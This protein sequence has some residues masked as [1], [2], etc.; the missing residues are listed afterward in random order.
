MGGGA[1][2]S[3]IGLLVAAIGGAMAA[4]GAVAAEPGPLSSP[5]LTTAQL[6]GQRVVHG[7]S[8]AAPGPDL[9]AR[10]RR[11]EV[12]GVIIMGANVRSPTQLRRLTDRLQA[13]PRPA[14][15]DAPLLVMID[16]EGGAVRRIHGAPE[17]SAS[18]IGRQGPA[19]AARAGLAAGRLLAASGV[20]VNLAPVVDVG[21]PGSALG[22]VGRLFGAAPA[23]VSIH[24]LAFERG[25][26]RAGILGTAKH[27]PG[28]G[29]AAV[30]TDDAP[31]TIS[32]SRAHLRSRHMRP[33]AAM[34]AHGVPL[35]MTSSAIY[36]GLHPGTPALLSARVVRGELRNRLGFGG[37]VITDALDTPALA[38]TG[39]ADRVTSRAAAA[40]NDLLLYISEA[41]GARAAQ[42]LRAELVSGRQSRV[43]AHEHLGR[44]ME[45]RR[46]L[47]ASD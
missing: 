37:V 1:G 14:S 30:N 22:R 26:R 16:Q 34:I 38:A 46:R 44:V 17:R 2:V 36:S 19:V 12:G 32:A 5:P 20:N 7:F 47:A 18:A 45:L 41:R 15:L 3:A 35:V 29:A 10:I 43:R 25:Q 39:S 21:D 33:F 40:G 4:A 13:I 24:A 31:V 8:G 28:L 6:A 23:A 11:G 42:V 27:F 9:V